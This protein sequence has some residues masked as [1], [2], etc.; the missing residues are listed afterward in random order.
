MNDASSGD[1]LDASLI[2]AAERIRSREV[3]AQELTAASLARAEALQPVIN[4]FIRIDAEAA[5]QAAELADREIAAGRY[6]G[7]LHGI[8]LAHKDMF[9]RAGEITSCGSDIRRDFRAEF[10][11]NLI[12]RLDEAGAVSV[13]WLNLSEFAGGPTGHNVHFGDCRNPWNTAHVSGGS[14]SGSGA[15]VAARIVFGALGSDTGGSIRIPAACCGVVGVKP[16]YGLVSRHG[17]MPRSWSLDHI[18]PLTRTVSD[19]AVILQA[20]AGVNAGDAT[21]WVGDVPD[22]RERAGRWS[23]GRANWRAEARF[24]RG[25]FA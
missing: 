12:A 23:E 18:G 15:A 14:S 1:L 3:S 2:E 11:S 4:A 6:R 7:V 19:S 24:R 20:I 9:Y 22:Y 8:P 10:T 16:T 21:S 25:C 17:A 13:G 5:M